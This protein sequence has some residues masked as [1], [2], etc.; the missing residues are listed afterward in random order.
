MLDYFN[1]SLLKSAAT[2]EGV[3]IL[4]KPYSLRQLSEALLATIPDARE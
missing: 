2:A 1:D 3:E 4:P